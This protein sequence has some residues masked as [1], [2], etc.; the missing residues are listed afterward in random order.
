MDANSVSF[1]S[2]ILEFA[3]NFWWL[4][5]ILGSL[6][7][8]CAGYMLKAFRHSARI[9][10]LEKECVKSEDVKVIKVL[11]EGQHEALK[12]L[13]QIDDKTLYLNKEKQ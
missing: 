6:I 10:A 1:I 2:D 7:A 11:E 12:K 5:A 8:G 9:E 3:R 13:Y 4:L